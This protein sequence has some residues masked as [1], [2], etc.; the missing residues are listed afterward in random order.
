MA[1][2]T[3]DIDVDLDEFDL[4]EILDEIHDRYNHK[5]ASKKDRKS[6]EEFINEWKDESKAKIHTINDQLKMHY[7]IANFEKISLTDLENI[8]L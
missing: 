4:D 6:I 5:N 3:T 1:T 8:T 7:F 2:I